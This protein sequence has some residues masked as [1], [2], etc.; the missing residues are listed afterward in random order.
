MCV[1]KPI[2]CTQC[3]CGTQFLSFLIL[4]VLYLLLFHFNPVSCALLCRT[5][6]LHRGEKYIYIIFFLLQ[7]ETCSDLEPFPFHYKSVRLHDELLLH[8]NRRQE[9]S[10]GFFPLPVS[11]HQSTSDDISLLFSSSTYGFQIIFHAEG[12]L[13]IQGCQR[14]HSTRGMPTLQ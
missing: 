11:W 3:I 1:I 10:S 14:C 7:K 4:F 12:S 13:L 5:Y 8:Q 6:C 9:I 2:F